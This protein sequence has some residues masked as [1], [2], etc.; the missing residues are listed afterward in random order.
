VSLEELDDLLASG[1]R[2]TEIGRIRSAARG[3]PD[4]RDRTDHG[5]DAPH[6]APCHA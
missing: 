4:P 3:G 5:D 6:A 2:P 1:L